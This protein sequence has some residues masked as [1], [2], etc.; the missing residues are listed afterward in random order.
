MTAGFI[1]V[2]VVFVVFYPQRNTRYSRK[3]IECF[4]NEGRRGVVWFEV[5][6]FAQLNSY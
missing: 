2:L 1:R 6:G 4:L 5:V 3:F